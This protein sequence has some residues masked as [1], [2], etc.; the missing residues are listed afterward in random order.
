MR[1]IR[2]IRFA[3][4]AAALI[5]FAPAPALA[6]EPSP[7]VTA[8]AGETA[9]GAPL[10]A[11]PEPSATSSGLPAASTPPAT[12]RAH[13]H[14]Y[15]AFTLAWLLVFGYALSLGRRFARLEREL[16]ARAS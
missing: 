16:N 13:W 8:P 11:A 1:F 9:P 12:L 7:A 3:L 10:V 4:A 5:A 14:V 6:Q 15:I 2:P